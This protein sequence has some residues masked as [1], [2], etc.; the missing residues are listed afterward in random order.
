MPEPEPWKESR[1]MKKLLRLALVTSVVLGLS[2]AVALAATN[3][4]PG[5]TYVGNAGQGRPLT[6]VVARKP[7]RKG[8]YK[9]TFKYCG[10]KLGIFITHGRF[11]VHKNAP[12]IGVPVSDFRAL[13]SFS[14]PTSAHGRVQLDLTS[15]CQGQPGD[16][17]LTLR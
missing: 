9:A 5:G 17:N 8:V 15:N 2:V 10:L 6:I 7:L 1:L 14:S 4:K 11:G 3:P 13:G 12:S 16:F